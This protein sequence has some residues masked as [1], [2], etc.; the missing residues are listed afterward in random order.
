MQSLYLFTNHGDSWAFLTR[1]DTRI[2]K[3]NK[4]T[5]M[6]SV[7][8]VIITVVSAILSVALYLTMP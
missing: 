3:A 4:K 1:N 5:D 2:I 8:L 6:M 7:F